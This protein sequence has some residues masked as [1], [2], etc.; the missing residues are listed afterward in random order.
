MYVK[1]GFTVLLWIWIAGIHQ[2]LL[3]TS[4]KPCSNMVDPEKTV[5]KERIGDMSPEDLET[6]LN[7]FG[8]KCKM[9]LKI[10]SR[11]G[12]GDES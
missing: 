5:I 6:A 12:F 1:K 3:G 4:I 11:D 8:F 9:N 2:T 10:S 7:Q